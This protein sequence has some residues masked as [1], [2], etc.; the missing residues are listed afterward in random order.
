MPKWNLRFCVIYDNKCSKPDKVLDLLRFFCFRFRIYLDFWLS[1]WTDV[2]AMKLS[3]KL[4]ILCI[5]QR[6]LFEV[7]D[8][9]FWPLLGFIASIV[10]LKMPTKCWCSARKYRTDIEV[11][12]SLHVLCNSFCI[13]RKHYHN[14]F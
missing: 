6:F 14:S 8:P 10:L 5:G 7:R 12:M 3:F 4:S 1:F 13:M 2:T 9:L 11:F